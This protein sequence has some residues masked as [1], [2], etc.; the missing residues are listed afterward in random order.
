MTRLVQ[1]GSWEEVF[2]VKLDPEESDDRD[3][4]YQPPKTESKSEESSDEE[5]CESCQYVR[6]K[7]NSSTMM[8]QADVSKVIEDQNPSMMK[9]GNVYKVIENQDAGN[10]A[11]AF[12]EDGEGSTD[13][14]EV[15]R[16]LMIFQCHFLYLVLQKNC[17][18]NLKEINNPKGC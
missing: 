9:Q 15:G 13:V 5:G 18:Q 6:P 7:L 3:K 14:A 17:G 11:F 10:E 16:N 8:K 12:D 4:D 2:T 1:N